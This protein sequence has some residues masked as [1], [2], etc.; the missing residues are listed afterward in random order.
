MVNQ[1]NSDLLQVANLAMKNA[2]NRQSMPNMVL[3]KKSQVWKNNES[4]GN[5]S[6]L[7]ESGSPAE[8]LSFNIA[9]HR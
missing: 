6:K 8:E 9:S 5:M 3:V 4:M 7:H 2:K 1:N